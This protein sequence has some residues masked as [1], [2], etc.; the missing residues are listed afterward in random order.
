MQK[1]RVYLKGYLDKGAV[2]V[3]GPVLDPLGSWGLVV[4]E[5]GSEEEAR[6]I[7]AKDPTV[8]S[9]LGFRWEIYPMLQALVRN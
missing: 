6:S 8:R 1:H 3:M 4:V 9:G 5:T 7:I 2:I